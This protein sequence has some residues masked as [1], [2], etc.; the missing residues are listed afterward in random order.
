MFCTG[1]TGGAI[2]RIGRNCEKDRSHDQ[3]KIPGI[4]LWFYFHSR[5]AE[6]SILS[7]N[8]P[9]QWRNRWIHHNE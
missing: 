3:Q 5:L 7:K 6:I 2:L 9:A 8:G 1:D 4:R